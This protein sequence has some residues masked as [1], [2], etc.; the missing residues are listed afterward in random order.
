MYGNLVVNF[1]TATT[2]YVTVILGNNEL[3]CAE[4]ILVLMEEKNLCLTCGK[5]FEHM[6]LHCQTYTDPVCRAC[7]AHEM[8]SPCVVCKLQL[9][10]AHIHHLA[11]TGNCVHHACK[12]RN[13]TLN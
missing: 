13:K 7:C 9:G 6:Y 12:Y 3:N 4:Q 1:R 8:K 10:H 5:L 2:P 11:E